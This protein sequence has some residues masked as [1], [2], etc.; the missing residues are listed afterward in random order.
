MNVYN[1]LVVDDA[2]KS[3]ARRFTGKDELTTLDTECEWDSFKRE[4]LDKSFI[5][6]NKKENRISFKIQDGDADDV[7]ENGLEPHRL[8]TFLESALRVLKSK[9]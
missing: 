3:F 6:I 4:I 5:H 7:G 8:A 1:P 9:N 2:S